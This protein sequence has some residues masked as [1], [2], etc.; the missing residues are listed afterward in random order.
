MSATYA[1]ETSSAHKKRTF[2]WSPTM[3]KQLRKCL[4]SYKVNMDYKGKDFDGNRVQQYAPLRVKMKKKCGK[5][6]FG[7]EKTH[8]LEDE[9]MVTQETKEKKIKLKLVKL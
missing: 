8:F 5:E 3:I 7:P 9:E 6:M 4:Y 1:K 2:R